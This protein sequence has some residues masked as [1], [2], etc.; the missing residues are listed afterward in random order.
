MKKP[1]W[2]ESSEEPLGSWAVFVGDNGPTTAKI[3]GR[4]HVTN[5]N[6]YF[7]AGLV[8]DQN[9]GLMMA[10]ESFGYHADVK[11][12][13]QIMDHRLQIERKRII[14]IYTSR[15]WLILRSLH[16]KLNGGE[17]FVFR[18][19]ACSPAGALTAL[20]AGTPA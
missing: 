18:F 7:D 15:E 5:R 10:G 19:G 6:V 4:L 1:D 9:A 8:L 2:M 13:F 14:R 12:P 16:L 11:P 3:T 20:Q 17:E